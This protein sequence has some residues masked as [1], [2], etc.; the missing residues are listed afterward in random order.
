MKLLRVYL[1]VF[2]SCISC[3][4]KTHQV[5]IQELVP[6]QQVAKEKQ[7]R[8]YIGLGVY[9]PFELYVND[10]LIKYGTTGV[11][12]AVEL[13]PWLLRNGTHKVTIK[14]FPD[15]GGHTVVNMGK[16][17]LPYRIDFNKVVINESRDIV[18]QEKAIKLP[19]L[20]KDEDLP[21]FEQ[22]WDIEITDLPYV[23]EGWSNGQDLSKWDQEVLEKKVVAYYEKLRRIL[24]DGDAESWFKLDEKRDIEIDVFDYSSPETIQ[25]E[26]DKN[27]RRIREYAKGN[28]IPLEDYKMKVYGKNNQLV[29]LERN[30]TN[31]FR[32]HMGTNIKYMS[33]I[34]FDYEGA[35]RGYPVKLYLPKGSDEFVIIRK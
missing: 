11:S 24:N 17:Q 20:T 6:T 25:R 33:P 31:G 10:I 23:L 9:L 8:Y 28:M 16:E 14:F 12:S 19:L 32:S 27:S 2:I 3:N 7:Y 29:T 18:K 4:S 5:A 26:F 30:A 22:S 15:V 1:V 35:I 21:Y 34:M 13:N